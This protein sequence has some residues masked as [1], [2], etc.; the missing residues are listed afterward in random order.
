MVLS[1]GHRPWC[2]YLRPYVERYASV[3]EADPV[4]HVHEKLPESFAARLHFISEHHKQRFAQ[5]TKLLCIADALK[6]YDRVLL[7]DDSCFVAPDSPDIFE[8]VPDNRMGG[9]IDS[10]LWGKAAYPKLVMNTGVLCVSSIHRTFFNQLEDFYLG[11]IGN[12]P[13]GDQHFINRVL[14]TGALDNLFLDARLNV[15]GSQIRETTIERKEAYIYHLTSALSFNQ[16]LMYAQMLCETY[17][18]A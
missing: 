14:A 1:V 4:F 8:L 10:G 9:V 6:S 11:F 3:C 7:L 12:K 16:R 13:T 18:L 5:L 15:V 17:P 2:G